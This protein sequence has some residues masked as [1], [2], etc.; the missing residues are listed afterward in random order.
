MVNKAMLS[1]WIMATGL[2]VLGVGPA[3]ADVH[4]EDRFLL[5]GQWAVVRNMDGIRM[6][7]LSYPNQ[8][9]EI[10]NAKFPGKEEI[11]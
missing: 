11:F 5:T 10:P 9:I 1:I 3:F 2:P 7:S 6:I 8:D 4:L